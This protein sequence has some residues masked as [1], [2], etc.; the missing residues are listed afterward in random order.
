MIIKVPNREK[1]FE[2]LVRF[3]F[4]REVKRAYEVTYDRRGNPVTFITKKS[5]SGKV[6]RIPIPLA[7]LKEE[8]ISDAGK[9]LVTY[10]A[11]R[12]TK[13]SKRINTGGKSF[14]NV[15]MKDLVS[16]L[17]FERG[18]GKDLAEVSKRPDVMACFANMVGRD[19]YDLERVKLGK[20][21]VDLNLKVWDRKASLGITGS[22]MREKDKVILNPAEL[23][24]VKGDDIEWVK[25]VAQ[26]M[27]RSNADEV[28]A[29]GKGKVD[30]VTL[31]TLGAEFE[32]PKLA[33]TFALT[34][35]YKLKEI[36]LAR[37]WQ[38]KKIAVRLAQEKTS[39]LPKILDIFREVLFPRR[40]GFPTTAGKAGS[41][42]DFKRLLELIAP[43]V[44]VKYKIPLKGNKFLD[45]LC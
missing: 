21:K 38:I 40:R 37:E 4:F 16:V 17:S 41:P 15:G 22:V 13:R 6:F 44:M 28:W 20:D 32:N 24:K 33:R 7:R 10:N 25:K 2:S 30:H 3:L 9:R 1:F 19:G 35:L 12:L 26:V 5:K 45:S 39:S 29:M 18:L 23:V 14:L 8:R 42:A 34:S 11:L 36:K 43:N 27:K 31:C